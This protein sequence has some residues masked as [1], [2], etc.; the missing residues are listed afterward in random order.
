MN[1]IKIKGSKPISEN[2][3]TI[4][5][6]DQ[7]TCLEISDSN[8]ARITGDLELTGA[9]SMSNLL[10]IDTDIDTDAVALATT[11]AAFDLKL[12]PGGTTVID[13]DW[14]DTTA[15]T[16]TALSVDLDKTGESSSDNTIYGINIDLDNTTPQAGDNTMYGIYCTPTL[17]YTVAS[18]TPI[19][20]GAYLNATGSSNGTSTSIGL[21]IDQAATGTADTNLGLQIRSAANTADYFSIDVTTEGATTITTVD[22]DT[23]AAHLTIDV[24]GDIILD[25]DGA[26]VI[27]KDNGTESGRISMDV[28]GTGAGDRFFKVASS[29]AMGNYLILDAQA[30]TNGGLQLEAE[31]GNFI[32]SKGG[33]EFSAV[34]SA[35]AGM[36]LGYTRIQNNATT[37]LGNVLTIN[38]SSMTVL[39]TDA[40][41]D[42][43]I[44]F[45][46]PPSGNVEIQCSFWMAGSSRGAKFSLSTDPSYAELGISHTYDADQTVYI[47]E[48]DHDITN[49]SFSVTGLTAGT[50]TT[51]YLAGLASGSSTLI[52]HGRFRLAGSHYPPI[53]LRAIALPATIVTGQ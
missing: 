48:T 5:V 38:S 46:V 45:I 9:L 1:D 2:L 24:D 25:A 42:F 37:S 21:L 50:D 32:M 10:D 53:I 3:S 43:S 11:D 12:K 14:S 29:T 47:D 16:I 34:N 39:Q 15:T 30:G 26:D 44:Q 17:T 31:G 49:I 20:I 6:G 40:G 19:V 22:A 51:Y 33:T 28:T 36:L 4:T 41:T 35:Y 7:R 8:G 52:N 18:G 23:A 27:Y 13:K